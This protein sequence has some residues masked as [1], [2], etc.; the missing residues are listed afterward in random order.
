MKK[1][2]YPVILASGSPRRK[3][4]LTAMGVDE[5]LVIPADVDEDSL[6]DADPWI[7]AR[8]L[9]REK[10]LVVFADYSDSIVIGGDTVVAFEN[11]LGEWVQLSKPED[12]EDAKRMLLI[13][14]GKTHVV[15]TGVCVKWPGGFSSFTDESRVTFKPMSEAEITQYVATGE[16]LDKAGGYG[17]QGGARP[18]VAKVEGSID[19]VIGLPTERLAEVFKDIT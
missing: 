5:F 12:A 13:L 1:L 11:S 19:N 4:L 17:L 3:D 8:K 18:F 9:A 14:S 16:P 6:T 10:A 7:T 2:P 15:I